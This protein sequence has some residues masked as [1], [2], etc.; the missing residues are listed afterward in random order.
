MY[1]H[2]LFVTFLEIELNLVLC[3]SVQDFGRMTNSSFI[4]VVVG[5]WLFLCYLALSLVFWERLKR[6]N[7]ACFVVILD[8]NRRNRCV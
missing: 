3:T 5:F 6:M 2:A 4:V 7:T 8:C 1:T